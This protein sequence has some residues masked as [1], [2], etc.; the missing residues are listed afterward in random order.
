MSDIEGTEL[1]CILEKDQK[2]YSYL[3]DYIR[4]TRMKDAKSLIRLDNDIQ[5]AEI[6]LHLKI[7]GLSEKDTPEKISWIQRYGRG[8]R[9][10]LN[11]IK[12][13]AIAWCAKSEDKPTW[14]EFCKLTE[15]ID[16]T[17]KCLD[18]IHR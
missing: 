10:Y 6:A 9:E 13:A 1:F 7:N 15:Q 11:T 18:G 16:S 2:T 8:F 17:K 14:E 4:Y 3:L 5:A 12:I